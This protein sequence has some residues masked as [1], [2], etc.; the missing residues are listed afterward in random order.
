MGVSVPA[1]EGHNRG[2]DAA[3]ATPAG[4]AKKDK[5]SSHDEHEQGSEGLERGAFARAPPVLQRAISEEPAI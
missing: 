5:P 1:G 2:S 3:M 4:T